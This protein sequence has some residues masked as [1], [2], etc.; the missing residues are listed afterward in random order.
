ML[1]GV[2][3]LPFLVA[4]HMVTR[5]Q[6]EMMHKAGLLGGV[7]AGVCACGKEMEGG[8]GRKVC[9]VNLAFPGGLGKW[10]AEGARRRRQCY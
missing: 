2:I 7:R 4:K 8:V 1:G 6:P 5:R 10:L 3:T 9:P